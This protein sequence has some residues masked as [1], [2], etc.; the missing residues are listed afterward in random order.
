MENIVYYL[1]LDLENSF[2][3]YA[4]HDNWLVSKLAKSTMNNK[5]NMKSDHISAVSGGPACL[6]SDLKRNPSAHVKISY[7]RPVMTIIILIGFI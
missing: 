5:A 6:D 7:Q 2:G 3:T 4:S 1:L